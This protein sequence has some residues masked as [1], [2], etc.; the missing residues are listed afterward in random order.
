MLNSDE[1]DYVLISS[2]SSCTCE[3][4]HLLHNL[5]SVCPL[6]IVHSPHTTNCGYVARWKHSA[7]SST[8]FLDQIPQYISYVCIIPVQR[9]VSKQCRRDSIQSTRE[10][11]RKSI[12]PL[13]FLRERESISG[14][15]SIIKKDVLCMCN[16]QMMQPFYY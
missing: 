5:T 6:F 12:V 11:E 2:L 7:V 4:N 10:R 8:S 9:S 3:S 13:S 14:G 16:K 1:K 15:G